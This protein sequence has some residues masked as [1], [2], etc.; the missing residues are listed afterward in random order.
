M[1]GQHGLMLDAHIK[2]ACVTELT[3]MVHGLLEEN[4]CTAWQLQQHDCI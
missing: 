1:H 2:G 3:L 4:A